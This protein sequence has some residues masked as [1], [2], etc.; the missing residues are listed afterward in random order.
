VKTGHTLM[1]LSIVAFSANLWFHAALFAGHAGHQQS[2]VTKIIVG[3]GS[4]G[5]EPG[6]PGWHSNNDCPN[7]LCPPNFLLLLEGL[8]SCANN[9]CVPS[10][11]RIRVELLDCEGNVLASQSLDIEVEG[12]GCPPPP[13]EPEVTTAPFEISVNLEVCGG[14]PTTVRVTEIANYCNTTGDL[15]WEENPSQG[16]EVPAPPLDGTL[17]RKELDCLVCGGQP[18]SLTRGRL[19]IFKEGDAAIYSLPEDYRGP[20]T[21]GETVNG[22]FRISGV[23]KGELFVESDCG[24]VALSSN[25]DVWGTADVGANGYYD[26]TSRGGE[27]FTAEQ[28]ISWDHA[29]GLTFPFN[30]RTYK[31]ACP[32]FRV[33]FDV[34]YLGPASCPCLR[35]D[36]EETVRQVLPIVCRPWGDDRPTPQFR[37]PGQTPDAHVELRLP[38]CASCDSESLV[39]APG[40]LT[41]WFVGFPA[42]TTPNRILDGHGSDWRVVGNA[43]HEPAD[44]GLVYEY[45]NP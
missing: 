27:A 20:A 5:G 29:A 7:E 35:H 42:T 26:G 24:G 9:G 15:W 8:L 32:A 10:P 2:N 3:S 31:G 40:G 6:D 30:I 14:T 22:R 23:T 17:S 43:L 21:F 39:C 19:Q 34:Y 36:R 38:C 44:G 41:D 33:A 28:R 45:E 18:A 4:G 25:V 37:G 1:S 12:S 16:M 11:P 13:F